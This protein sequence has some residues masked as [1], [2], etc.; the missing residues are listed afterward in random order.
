MMDMLSNE[1][2]RICALMDQRAMITMYDPKYGGVFGSKPLQLIWSRYADFYGPHN[3]IMVDDAKRNFVTSPQ[4]GLKIS[5]F[6]RGA[7]GRDADAE[8][9]ELERYVLAIAE[10]DDF[11][12]LKHKNWKRYLNIK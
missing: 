4:N 8:L 3:T 11:T 12:H 5:A 7:A 1:E 2:Y 6:R 10:L 9:A